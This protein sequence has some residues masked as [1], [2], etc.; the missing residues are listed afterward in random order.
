MNKC[1]TFTPPICRMSVSLSI[2]VHRRPQF[3]DNKTQAHGS[4]LEPGLIDF[5][6]E[7]K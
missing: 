5:G 7:N 1:K 3:A 2:P 6:I 4:G